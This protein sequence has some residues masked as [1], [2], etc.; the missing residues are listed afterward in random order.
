MPIP[1]SDISPAARFLP[2]TTARHGAIGLTLVLA[3]AAMVGVTASA[4][5]FMN[6]QGRFSGIASESIVRRLRDRLAAH[7]QHVP[8]SWHDKVQ[9][10]DIVQRCTSDVDTVRLF[11]REQV[12]EIAPHMLA[13]RHRI[14]DSALA[15]LEDGPVRNGPD[16]GDRRLRDHLFPQG[17]GIVQ[18]R[19]T[20]PRAS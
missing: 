4:A 8:M 9:T 13:N 3:A 19:P 11:Y 20:R 10:G 15:R 12:I 7:L 18:E 16:A 5:V 14:P 17:A 1:T 6:L 2:R